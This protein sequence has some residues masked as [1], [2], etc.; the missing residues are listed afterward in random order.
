[1]L[2]VEDLSS[3]RRVSVSASFSL[4]PASSPTVCFSLSHHPSLITSLVFGFILSIM[5]HTFDCSSWFF[6]FV[7]LALSILH[8]G[9]PVIVHS[10]ALMY[11]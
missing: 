7:S 9:F 8:V 2:G 5:L 4:P 3:R 10:S 6:L 1:V 11:P